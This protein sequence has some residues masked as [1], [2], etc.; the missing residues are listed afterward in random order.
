[1]KEN[2]FLLFQSKSGGR[3]SLFP[4]GSEGPVEKVDVRLVTVTLS[5]WISFWFQCLRWHG[6]YGHHKMGSN[7]V[8]L[9]DISCIK[10][11]RWFQMNVHKSWNFKHFEVWNISSVFF[12][13][14]LRQA[15]LHSTVRNL[16]LHFKT[17]LFKYWN[18]KCLS[19]LINILLFDKFSFCLQVKNLQWK[20]SIFIVLAFKVFSCRRSSFIRER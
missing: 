3:S 16:R 1:M 14:N 18:V 20:S 6:G 19:F 2:I 17:C 11:Q 15:C 9:R 8:W 7:Y 10:H 12:L 5:Y 4:L 13:W